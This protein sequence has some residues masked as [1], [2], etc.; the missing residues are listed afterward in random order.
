MTL[1]VGKLLRVLLVAGVFALAISALFN[2]RNTGITF[3]LEDGIDLTI[4]SSAF[5]NGVPVPSSTWELKD[6]VPGVDKFFDLAGILPGDFGRAAI[7]AHIEGRE[8]AWM[9]LDFLSTPTGPLADGTHF[10]AWRDD[11]DGVFQ[12]GE[13]LLFDVSPASVAL[14]GKTYPIADST[15]GSVVEIGETQHV[16]IE[17]CAGTL[18]FDGI[19]FSCDGATLGNEAQG[20]SFSV[21][22]ALRA[23]GSRDRGAFTCAEGFADPRGERG[24]R[25]ERDEREVREAR[26]A[27]PAR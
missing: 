7:S 23:V 12:L 2:G 14:S 24:E 19:S 17:W 16:G 22:I 25:D 8:T 5:Y 11:G 21:D 13:S 9:C 6:L 1:F 3:A 20:D 18:S 4:G 15:T 27:R 10:F 26:P